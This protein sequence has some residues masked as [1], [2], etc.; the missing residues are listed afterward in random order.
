MLI[1]IVFFIL[2]LVGLWIGAGLIVEAAKK[3]AIFFKIS[4]T[5][6]GLTIISIGTSLPE[7]MT[8]VLS[9]IQVKIGNP[10]SGIAIG[11]NIGSCATQITFIIGLTA[12]LGTIFASKK[13]LFRDGSM[14]LFSIICLFLVGFDGRV[15]PVEGFLLVAIYIIYLFF[16]SRDEHVVKNVATE[17]VNHNVK[18]VNVL[19]QIIAM[20]VGFVVLTF[21]SHLVVDN[22]LFLAKAWGVAESFIG[23]MIIGVSTGLPELSTSI[24]AILKKASGISAGT[25]IGSNITDPLFSLGIGATI[26]GF[27][28]DK[29]LLF[30]DIPFWFCASLI[31]LSML[32][33]K[34]SMGWKKGI[35]CIAMYA[36]FAVL[37]FMF[38]M[39]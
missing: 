13:L 18:R 25:L 4:Q 11:T 17:L 34:K 16:I 7:I 36:V 37:K 19:T 29:N 31:T 20:L 5:L 35:I 30:F 33:Y 6:I 26:A 12:I 14:V 8:N 15:T 2:G 21:A 27:T 39:R 28:F 10:A 22:A 24:R 23:V 1:E 3:L 38:F 32:W 9:G